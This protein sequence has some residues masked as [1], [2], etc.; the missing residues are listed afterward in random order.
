MLPSYADPLQSRGIALDEQSSDGR[1]RFAHF[2]LSLL[3][4]N[5]ISPYAAYDRDSGS[6][7][8]VSTFVSNND[9]FPVPSRLH[10]RTS[11]YRGGI[12]FSLK[13]FHATLEQGGTRFEDDQTLYQSGGVNYGNSLAPVFGQ[14]LD[15]T[16]LLA[17][18]GAHGTSIYTKALVTA[19]PVSWLDF[20]GQ[21]LYSQPDTKV[22]YQQY[23]GGNFYLQSQ[24]VFYTGQQYLISSAAQM[25]HTSGTAGLEI[26]PWRRIRLTESWLTDRL[27]SA[28][29]SAQNR[30]LTG[31]QIQTQQQ[32][33]AL[34]ASLA[35]NYNQVEAM[36][37]FDATSRLTVRGG[38]RY[39]WGDAN[40]I[41]LPPE[42][43]A[44]SD[45]VR[46]RRNVGIGGFTYRPLKRFSFSAE[47]ESA[48]SGGAY[49]R[50]SL[51]NYQK[52]RAQMRY[53]ATTAF[54]FSADFN[55]LDNQNPQPGVNSDF[56]THQ[57]SLSVLW[58]PGGGKTLDL[59]GSYSRSDLRS[60]IGYL[61]PGTLQAQLS[62]YRDNSHAATA[63]F[64]IHL[65]GA[66]AFAPQLTAGGSLVL[67]S[68]SRPTSYYQP[69]AKLVLPAGK[70]MMLFTE[71]RYYGY[72]EGFYLEGFRA[73]LATAGVRYTR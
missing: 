25:P 41:T 36:L 24:L 6:G 31:T 57:E 56:L 19:N 18:Y 21:F 51:F 65:P 38:Y 45:R 5:W 67:S 53:Q 30:T 2:D 12:R 62:R 46:M 54:S 17:A 44:S 55:L 70:H 58:T 26:R 63:V 48:S 73:H 71:W 3:P 10:D 15:L 61:D 69:T 11:N 27:H 7:S 4:G 68:G 16:D 37:F 8:G 28:A 60:N 66:G 20:Y 47:G 59:Q 42:G 29:S 52:A 35:S 43:L 1:R 64:R 32:I 39:V 9:E 33:S 13:R 34:E 40:D 72:A 50:T 22:N 23:A 14:T 49:F